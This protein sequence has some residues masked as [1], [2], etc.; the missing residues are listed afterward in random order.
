M[1]FW[2]KSVFILLQIFAAGSLIPVLLTLWTVLAGG[3]LFNDSYF[4]KR[5]LGNFLFQLPPQVVSTGSLIAT[6]LIIAGIW[7]KDRSEKMRFASYAGFILLLTIIFLHLQLPFG[8]GVTLPLTILGCTA[9]YTSSRKDPRKK[10]FPGRKTFASL[11]E[12]FAALIILSMIVFA[13]QFIFQEGTDYFLLRKEGFLFI[14]A[15]LSG[16]LLYSGKKLRDYLIASSTG[17]LFLAA[18]FAFITAFSDTLWIMDIAI[19]CSFIFLEYENLLLLRG[20]LPEFKNLSLV[21]LVLLLLFNNKI[22]PAPGDPTIMTL[23]V[24]ILYILGDNCERIVKNI[25]RKLDPKRNFLAKPPEIVFAVQAWCLSAFVLI[26]LTR[27]RG[28]AAFLFLTVILFCTGILKML[29]KQKMPENNDKT[30]ENKW[31]DAAGF[32]PL[33]PECCVI[34]L[35]ALAQ[36]FTGFRIFPAAIIAAGCCGACIWNLGNVI[37]GKDARKLSIHAS[38]YHAGATGM[39][40]LFML[41]LFCCKVSSNTAAGTGLILTGCTLLGE[42]AYVR[43]SRI[44]AE[45][46][47]LR[48]WM[49]YITIALGLAFAAFPGIP[50]KIPRWDPAAVAC[51]AVAFFAVN[52]YYIFMNKLKKQEA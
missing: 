32:F 45:G 33:L 39:I 48:K 24:F 10:L 38:L 36:F 4:S 44:T 17:F 42:G 14:L 52:M 50:L 11:P 25:R 7:K 21:F 13:S 30:K 8:I 41:L 34:L 18:V 6:L 29:L 22:L 19:I 16:C 27:G 26:C 28:V 2:K 12:R 37:T 15:P 5:L 46:S 1:V 49:A 47:L 23:S 35:F 43:F 9:L 51:G 40:F 3:D 20:F 31:K